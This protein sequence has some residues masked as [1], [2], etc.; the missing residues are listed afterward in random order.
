MTNKNLAAISYEVEAISVENIYNSGVSKKS[1]EMKIN[2]YLSNAPSEQQ[3]VL[4]QMN[5]TRGNQAKTGE[6]EIILYNQIYEL[7]SDLPSVM[8]HI[9]QWNNHSLTTW[10]RAENSV[11]CLLPGT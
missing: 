5:E 3:S 4:N 8:I 9:T 11:F 1:P 10:M 2:Q 7:P 6:K